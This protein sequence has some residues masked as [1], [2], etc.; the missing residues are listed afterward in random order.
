MR[1]VILGCGGS[2]GVPMLGGDTGHG[3]FGACDPAEPRN[4]RTRS[5]IVIEGD[6][7]RRV[8]VDTGPEM[9]QQLLAC[10]IGRIDAL[11]YTHAH[12]D[13]VA[14]LDDIRGLNRVADRP[15]EAFGTAQVLGEIQSRFAY[16]FRPW[17]PPGFYRPVLQAHPVTPGPAVIEGMQFVLFEQIH[18]RSIT[19]GLRVGAFAYS[20]DVMELDESA[21]RSLEGVDTWVVGCF[22]RAPHPAHAHPELIVRWARQL[23]I[24]RTILTHMGTDLDWAWM[25]S[26]LQPGLEPAFDGMRIH[27]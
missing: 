5:A 8:L 10:G 24:R 3:D 21:L 18:G 13:H 25:A 22:Q 26:N 15:L 4:R 20:T 6:D 14:G 17:S 23:G 16:A 1:V 9:R 2:A 7:G 11:F 12:A 19:I 27:L